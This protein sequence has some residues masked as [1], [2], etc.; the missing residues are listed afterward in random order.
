MTIRRTIL[1][2][3]YDNR[4]I[5][6]HLGGNISRMGREQQLHRFTAALLYALNIFCQ[7]ILQMRMQ[8]RL[9]LLNSY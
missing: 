9:R 5:E 3:E 6:V 2:I 4:P 7:V 1:I 8:M